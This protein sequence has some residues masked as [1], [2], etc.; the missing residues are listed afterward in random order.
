MID[1][2]I[3]NG[4]IVDGTG[5]AACAGDVAIQGGM[6]VKIA[7][8]I[9]EDAKEVFDA[10]GEVVCPGFIDIHSHTDA[11]ITLNP[12]AESKIRQG[13]TTEVVGNCGMSVAPLTPAYLTEVKD[14][15]KINSDFRKT[16]DLGNAWNSFGEYIDHLN[17][18]P[19]GI[20]LMPLV[21]F[22]TLRSAVMGHKAGPPSE[23]E[24]RAME[25]LLE[26]SL[27][28]GAI[29]LSTGLEYV[30]ES[31]SKTEEL[32]RLCRVVAR[33]DKLYATHMRSESQGL[34][35]A[36]EEAIRTS[37]ESGCRLQISHLKLGGKFNWGET[38]RLFKMLD[39]AVARGVKLT[40]DQYPYA[41]W[42]SGL[43]DYVPSW[44]ISN[45]PEKM[46]ARLSD[47]DT[48][49][50]IR[51]QVDAEIEEGIHAY[52]T[53]PWDCVQVAMVRSEKAENIMG[54]RIADL[55]AEKNMDPIDYV[56]DLLVQE[57]GL[58]KILVFCMSEQDIINIMLHPDTIIS[59]DARAVADYGELSMGSPHPRYYGAFPRV[60]GK[61]VREEGLLTLEDAIR[62]MTTLPAKALKLTD[63]G[64]L[65]PGMIA[66]ITIFNPDE[67][68][69]VATFEKPHQYSKG[70]RKVMISGRTVID[71]AEHTG[72]MLGEVI[73]SSK[74]KSG[75]QGYGA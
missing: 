3:K 52:N 2:L 56:F 13:V 25:N 64:V 70:I 24:F 8:E 20:N 69:D 61:Y 42:G 36:I 27:D 19:I 39:D 74:K 44:V 45:G 17:G 59:S 4:R 10:A 53:A 23:A 57:D 33:K 50:K 18:L 60:L 11:T 54:R 63:R 55:A 41:A 34:F 67:I 47:P 62:K 30:P 58:V 32:I 38:D 5:A 29:G 48:R 73:G 7:P 31:F 14:H 6:I 12:R 26:R 65:A 21:G 35:P 28:E 37:E 75:T 46:K 66:D 49:R 1:L 68:S 16:E 51:A 71:G 43:V 9:T 22:G 15:L 40:W 72:T